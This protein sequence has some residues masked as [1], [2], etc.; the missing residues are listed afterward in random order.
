MVAPA[1][2]CF[3]TSISWI[4]GFR[5]EVLARDLKGTWS[6]ALG[7]GWSQAR[8]PCQLL[9]DL[10]HGAVC[11]SSSEQPA[12]G[13]NCYWPWGDSVFPYF[14]PKSPLFQSMLAASQSPAIHLG[15]EPNSSPCSLLAA[16]G[17]PGMKT[18]DQKTDITTSLW[19]WASCAQGHDS[20]GHS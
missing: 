15:A 11:H 8:D 10:H 13:L 5:A 3:I 17:W 16:V 7:L 2:F 20:Y 6:P 19:K 14:Q 12:S 18:P 9:S 4:K 1:P